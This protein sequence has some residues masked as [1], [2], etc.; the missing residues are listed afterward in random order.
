VD[1]ILVESLG[2]TKAYDTFHSYSQLQMF[3]LAFPNSFIIDN[4]MGGHRQWQRTWRVVRSRPP[5][6]S[7]F[8][9]YNMIALDHH[10]QTIENLCVMVGILGHEITDI[11]EGDTDTYFQGGEHGGLPTVISMTQEQ[12]VGIGSDKILSFPWHPGVHLLVGC[13]TL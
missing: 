9:T 10:R 8:M 13:F 1:E 11:S 5:D 7:S 2:L 6:K 3:L 4:S 12:L